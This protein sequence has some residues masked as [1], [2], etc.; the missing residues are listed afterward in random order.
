MT[1]ADQV[2]A[3]PSVRNSDAEVGIVTVVLPS[4]FRPEPIIAPSEG[5]PGFCALLP[6]PDESAADVPLPSSSFHQPARA[7]FTVSAAL[8][9]VAL[10]T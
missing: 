2:N 5:R 10:P 4:I 7:S 6:L 1:Q 9:L 8:L 3:L